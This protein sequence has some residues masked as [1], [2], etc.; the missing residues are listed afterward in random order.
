MFKNYIFTLLIGF[1]KQLQLPQLM[2]YLEGSINFIY[3]FLK[4]TEIALG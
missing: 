1:N 3:A 4:K 2:L